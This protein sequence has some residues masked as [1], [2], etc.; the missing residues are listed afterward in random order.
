[1]KAFLGKYELDQ[2]VRQLSHCAYD[3]RVESADWLIFTR[4][5]S[6]YCGFTSL[7]LHALVGSLRS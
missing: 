3:A 5:H 6:L 1:M 7:R 2:L 4:Q